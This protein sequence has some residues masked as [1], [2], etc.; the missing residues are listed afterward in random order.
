MEEVI[1]LTIVTIWV[2]AM[3]R[4]T[5]LPSQQEALM[6]K[7]T[8]KPNTKENLYEDELSKL[9]T[10]SNVPRWAIID[11]YRT[12]SVGEHTFRVCAIVLTLVREFDRRGLYVS[13]S[14]ALELAI[15][16]DVDEAW[17]GD[18]PTPFKRLK[19]LQESTFRP[20]TN[21]AFLVKLADLLEATIFLDRY[22]V[23]A[24]EVSDR[25]YQEALQMVRDRMSNDWLWL[26]DFVRT[27]IYDKGRY[28]Q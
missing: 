15:L 3:R 17:S 2:I 7:D 9:F 18:L 27:Q 10:L 23:N 13:K 14:K 28:L 20:D 21:E 8:T 26:T 22:G 5:Y 4:D 12:Q 19:N 16:H 11:K 25:I 24:K 1:I 6:I